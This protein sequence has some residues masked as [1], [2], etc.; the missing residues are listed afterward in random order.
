MGAYGFRRSLTLAMQ[1]PSGLP[2]TIGDC[3]VITKL[4]WL[5]F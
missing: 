5:S 1:S 4:A 2:S 3:F